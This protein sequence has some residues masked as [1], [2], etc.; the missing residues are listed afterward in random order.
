MSLSY[1]L[2]LLD[3]YEM[4][5]E[6]KGDTV[7]LLATK[8]FITTNIHPSCWFKWD[9]RRIQYLALKRRI[10]HVLGFL[11]HSPFLLQ[12]DAF[13]GELKDQQFGDYS[14]SCCEWSEEPSI[15][16]MPSLTE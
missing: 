14:S 9:G 6:V 7:P 8:I 1:V 10:H 11:N 2:Q 5:V 4:S 12:K 15:F 13:F 3:R 16:P